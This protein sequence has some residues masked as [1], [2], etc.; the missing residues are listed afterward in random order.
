MNATLERGSSLSVLEKYVQENKNSQAIYL[1][2]DEVL[3]SFYCV[4]VNP[5]EW[6]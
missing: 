1:H 5:T 6:V 4:T 2:D 3:C